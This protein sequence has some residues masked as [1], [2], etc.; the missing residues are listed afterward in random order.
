MDDK[1]KLI[2]MINELQNEKVIN[3]IY[4]LVKDLIK[5]YS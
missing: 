2:Q 5:K 3:L 1:Q 4:R